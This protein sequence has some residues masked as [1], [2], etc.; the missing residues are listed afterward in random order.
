MNERDQQERGSEDEQT[1]APATSS[2]AT[3]GDNAPAE[4]ENEGGAESDRASER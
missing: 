3:A 4:K 1:Q 2:D